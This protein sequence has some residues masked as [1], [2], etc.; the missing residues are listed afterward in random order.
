MIVAFT[1]FCD[2]KRD[3]KFNPNNEYV[4]VSSFLS[5][6]LS[7]F[8]KASSSVLLEPLGF[9]I[10]PPLNFNLITILMILNNF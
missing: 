8:G 3:W 5:H 7:S 6:Q 10:S 1:M 9:V 4:S 2:K